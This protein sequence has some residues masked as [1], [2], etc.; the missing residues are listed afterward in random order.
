MQN[1]PSQQQFRM[2]FMREIMEMGITLFN[3]AS[4]LIFQHKV[5][6]VE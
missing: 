3:L 6:P 1:E 2:S 5:Q 4:L